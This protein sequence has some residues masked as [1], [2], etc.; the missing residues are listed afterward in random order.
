MTE[1]VKIKHNLTPGMGLI[2]KWKVCFAATWGLCGQG[3]TGKCP[4]GV[5]RVRGFAFSC[6]FARS[7]KC[8][9]LVTGNGIQSR[10]LHGGQHKRPE[11]KQLKNKRISNSVK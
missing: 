11:V 8:H 4:A 10:P 7:F 1:S 5:G 9:R 6:A 3:R 2:P